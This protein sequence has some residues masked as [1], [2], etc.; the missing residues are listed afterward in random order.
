LRRRLSTDEAHPVTR[1]LVLDDDVTL[2][3]LLRAVLE[4]AAFEVSASASAAELPEG[5]FDAIV[6][7][8]LAATVYTFADARDRLLRLAGRYPGVPVIVVTA[9]AEAE[10][11]RGALPARQVVLKPFDIDKLIAAVRDAT[12]TS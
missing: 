10:R 8:L 6:T 11:D 2:V 3:E 4:D 5:R 9:H 12:I 1:V 7:D